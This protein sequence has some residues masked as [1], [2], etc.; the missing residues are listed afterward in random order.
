MVKLKHHEQKLLRK[1]DFLQWKS[2]NTLR[3]AQVLRRYHVSKREDY[4]KYNK[5]VG[6]VAAMVTKLKNM[7]VDDAQ[8]AEISEG[9]LRKLFAMGVIDSD[10]SLA[11]ADNV[12]VSAMCRRRLPVVMFRLKMAESVKEAVA[13]VEQ[14]NVRVGPNTVTDPAFL[15][16]RTQEDYITWTADSK[17]RRHIA[18]Y[19][20]KLDDYDLMT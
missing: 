3:E 20:G 10:A 16:T 11:K 5:L 19:N 9:L 15:V 12:T 18:K 1:V 13:F 4:V 7:K 14:G 8:R 17:I 6:Q 2:D